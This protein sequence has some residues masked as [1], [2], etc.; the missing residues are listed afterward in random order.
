M[1]LRSL[2][3]RSGDVRAPV[4]D[5]DLPWLNS[6]P[7]KPDNLLGRVVVY[8]F[9]TYTCVNWLRTLPYIRAWV[10]QYRENGLLVLGVHTPEFSFEH[11]VDNVRDAAT[12]LDV[13][14]PI[15]IDND[16]EIWSAFGNHY[17]PALYI[18]NAKG[19]IEH[20]HFGEG[21][22]EQAE[23][24]IQRLLVDAG[25]A[26]VPDGFVDVEPAGVE[27]VAAER[28]SSPETYLG[29]D[30][31]AAFVALRGDSRGYVIPDELRLN[32]WAL[33]GNWTLRRDSV[34]LDGGRGTIA[35]RFRAR[36]VNLVLASS[37]G[38]VP[39]RVTVDGGPPGPQHGLDCDEDGSGVLMRP[40]MNQLVRR[41]SVDE[42]T[43]EVTF[44]KA[45]VG[46]YVF[47]FG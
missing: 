27:L 34:L 21:G 6:P 38:V 9:W 1:T 28:T 25:A 37:D 33:D 44:Q 24:V 12:A 7:L 17:W 31:G 20:H 47:T 32:T 18:A 39:F 35:F 42:Q 40:R 30:R 19:V 4:L 15:L 22:Y 11:D 2:L 14:Y 36:D 10:R 8:D 29:L 13:D 45:G 46:A 5:H 26:D 3:R 43:V 23:L 16:Y 41:G